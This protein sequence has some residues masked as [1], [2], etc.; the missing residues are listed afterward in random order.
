MEIN[1]KVFKLDD[2]IQSFNLPKTIEI[3]KELKNL[4]V[5]LVG[6][7]KEIFETNTHIIYP[8]IV[9][10]IDEQLG[11]LDINIDVFKKALMCFESQC[12]DFMPCYKYDVDEMVCLN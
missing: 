4:R 9:S 7:K 10:K 2:I 8:D 11:Y 12:F 5:E 6:D 3:F 1:K